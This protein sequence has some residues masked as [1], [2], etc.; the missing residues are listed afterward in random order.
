M[1]KLFLGASLITTLALV[2]VLPAIAA[3]NVSAEGEVTAID[4]VAGSFTL[5]AGADVYA[6][7]P[8]AGFDL[9][10]LSVGDQ[11]SV[12]GSLEAG[13]ITA[14]SVEI[15]P[16]GEEIEV[17]GEV[18]AIAEAS[19]DIS[20]EGTA[21]SV[22][23][24]EGFDLTTLAV[25]DMVLVHG[26]LVDSTITA[27][28]IEILPP[29]PEPVEVEEH[30]FVTAIAEASLDIENLDGEALTVLPP[31][32]FDLA[33]LEVGDFVFVAGLQ[34]ETTIAASEVLIL[35][36][37]TATGEVSAIAQAPAD[38]FT[39][40]V[41]PTYTV[42][43]IGDFD[44]ASLEV[45]DNV[46]VEGYVHDEVIFATDIEILPEKGEAPPNDGFYCTNPDARHPAL[47]ALAMVYGAEYGQLLNYFCIGHYGVGEIML[48]LQTAALVNNGMTAGD[49]LALKAE[50]G[51]WGQVW[52][53]FRL[54]GKK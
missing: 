20:V 40:E 3:V 11:V 18:S 21:Y 30:G 32:G 26:L 38:S 22:V 47:N 50:L 2:A 24:P 49:I 36:A 44:L 4:A 45:G 16:E 23:P 54:K 8:P 31:E 43:P 14:T 33:S 42:I 46:T 41:N 34:T 29:A 19:F 5:Q 7:I 28:S 53:Q 1:A 6:V 27:D 25:G 48:A 9:A 12:E 39:L 17:T 13:V 37:I 15:L 35:E 52:M 51:G 10:G